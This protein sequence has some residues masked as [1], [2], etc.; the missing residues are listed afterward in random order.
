MVRVTT[1]V[2]GAATSSASRCTSAPSTASTMLLTTAKESPASRALHHGVQ[3][4]LLG[5]G[6]RGVRAAAGEGGDAPVRGVARLVGVPGLVRAVEGAQSQ[7]DDPHGALADGLQARLS[8]GSSTAGA[9][10]RLC[11]SMLTV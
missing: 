7:V 9:A 3:P 2:A 4:V 5:Q 1:A 11:S 8:R 6:Q 10:A